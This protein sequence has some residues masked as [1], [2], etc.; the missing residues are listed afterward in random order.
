MLNCSWQ[1]SNGMLNLVVKTSSH[2][3]IIAI[4]LKSSDKIKHVTADEFAYI[5]SVTK[6]VRVMQRF[7]D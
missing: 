3:Q 6:L 7:K 4:G 5:D 2:P 1:V